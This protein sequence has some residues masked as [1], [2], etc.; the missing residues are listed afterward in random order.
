MGGNFKTQREKKEVRKITKKKYK[1]YEKS[2]L[3]A[4]NA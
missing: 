4:N 3:I 2:Y 1:Q